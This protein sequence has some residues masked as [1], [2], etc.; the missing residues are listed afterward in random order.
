MEDAARRLGLKPDTLKKMAR[1]GQIKSV[2]YP[3]LRRFEPQ[4]LRDY[5]AKHR[6]G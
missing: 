6:Q 4:V 2:K 1:C 3:K 5:I